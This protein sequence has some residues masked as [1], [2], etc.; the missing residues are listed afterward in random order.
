M[1]QETYNQMLARV[2]AL[3]SEITPGKWEAGCHPANERLNIVKPICFGKYVGK[4]PECEGGAVYFLHKPNAEAISAIPDMIALIEHQARLIE[5]AREALGLYASADL[6]AG[7]RDEDGYT[8]AMLNDMSE[9][10]GRTAGLWSG[11][12]ARQTLAELSGGKSI[13]QA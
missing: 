12:T 10:E 7:E 5:L 11:K 4:L 1:T 8:E 9:V 3:K 6:Y 2:L 13:N